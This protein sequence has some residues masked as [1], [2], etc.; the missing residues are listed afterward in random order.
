MKIQNLASA[1]RRILRSLH[2]DRR[3][4]T[5][6]EY[7][8]MLALIAIVSMLPVTKIGVEVRRVFVASGERLV[9]IVDS[10]LSAHGNPHGDGEVGNPHDGGG[11]GDPH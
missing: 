2:S 9:E 5:M 3:G 11:T 1:C 6:V 4:A 7:A 8:C 10:V